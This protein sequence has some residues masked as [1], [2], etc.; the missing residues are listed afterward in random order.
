MSEQQVETQ[1]PRGM[2]ISEEQVK[3]VNVLLAAVNVAQQ[4]GAYNFADSAAV[5]EAVKAFAPPA[6]PAEEVAEEV[7]SD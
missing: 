1:E 5:F 3:S 7:G 6:P 2:F 4:K